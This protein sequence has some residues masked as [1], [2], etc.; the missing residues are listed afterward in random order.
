VRPI[1]LWVATYGLALATILV[2]LSRRRGFAGTMV[3]IFA[4]LAFPGVGALAYL[5]LANPSVVRTNRHRQRAAERVR[6]ALPPGEPTPP[7]EVARLLPPIERSLLTLAARTTGLPATSGNLLALLTDN[8]DAFAH[9]EHALEQAQKL[10]WAEYYIINDDDTGR[11][12]LTLLAERARKGVEVRL[13]YDAVGSSRMDR[14]A[15]AALRDAGGKVEAFLPVNPFRR[16]WA[17]HLR[18]HRKILVVDGEVGFTGGMNI[19]DEYSGSGLRRRVRKLLPWRDTHLL[20]RGPAVRDLAQIFAEDWC[21]A[22][23]ELLEPPSAA[24]ATMP[25]SVVAILPSG[26]DQEA[27]ANG[28]TY[29]SGIASATERCYLTSPYFIPDDAT[30]RALAAAALRG[31][32]VRILVPSLSDVLLMRPAIRSYYPT[33]VRSGV[34]IYEY[35]PAML[36]AKTM[37][38]DGKF[39]TIGSANLDVRSFRLNFEVSALVCDPEFARVLEAQYQA[40][41]ARSVEVTAKTLAGRGPIETVIEG[42]AQLLSPLL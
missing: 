16:R 1:L 41:L 25:G 42:A 27:N 35:Q 30:V 37:V 26:P 17:I 6:Q 4:I 11:R 7:S 15:L 33:L 3:W 32:D 19:G 14:G 21:F 20:L 40:D 2:A 24:P 36:H 34:R 18:N 10:I 9:I 8:G 31:V 28:L 38:V 22:T 13:L 12:F 5:L 23:D 39:G 29:F